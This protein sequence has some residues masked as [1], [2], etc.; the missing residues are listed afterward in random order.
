MQKNNYIVES[1]YAKYTD[2]TN[3]QKKKLNESAQDM[4]VLVP[5]QNRYDDPIDVMKF[6]KKYGV[7]D[8]MSKAFDKAEELA[9]DR[10]DAFV[11]IRLSESLTEARNP[12]GKP[13]SEL[14][15]KERAK[16]K[17]EKEELRKKW[18]DDYKYDT[19]DSVDLGG[20]P[21]ANWP[22]KRKSLSKL[23]PKERA[24]WEK[25][26][27]E[28]K[29]SDDYKQGRVDDRV[30]LGGA[31]LA[32]ARNPENDEVNAALRKWADGGKLTGKEKAMIKDRNITLPNRRMGEPVRGADNRWMYRHQMQTAHPDADLA[33]AL[34][35]PRLADDDREQS[36]F[37][38]ETNYIPKPKY[39]TPPQAYH[40]KL[41]RGSESQSGKMSYNQFKSLQPYTKEKISINDA[42]EDA[43]LAQQAMDW[44]DERLAYAKD[45]M[46]YAQKRI[47]EIQDN[48]KSQ[49]K[50]ID[51]RNNPKD[52][53]AYAQRRIKDIQDNKKRYQKYIDDKNNEKKSIVDQAREKHANRNKNESLSLKEGFNYD[54]LTEIL[55]WCEKMCD[56]VG[57]WSSSD[58]AGL[59][60]DRIFPYLNETQIQYAISDIEDDANNEE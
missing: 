5:T 36:V 43:R 1:M 17:K 53:I 32:E 26:M 41:A 60:L 6:A 9:P 48:K 31:P 57:W 16:W 7:F 18:G 34:E 15:P 35:K 54:D 51:N 45:G 21:I 12:E 30:D 39:I 46:A 8:S 29:K 58:P 14:T 33:N 37:Y 49:Q 11:P 10:W 47:K 13:L 3:V 24:K 27:E 23:T 52:D 42:K 2:R 22:P 59:F 19:S 55:Y 44:E 40:N 56:K 50:Y 28:I 38:G 4:W 20:A 25:D